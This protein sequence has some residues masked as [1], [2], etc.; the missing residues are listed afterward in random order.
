MVARNGPRR[1]SLIVFWAAMRVVVVAAALTPGTGLAKAQI[2]TR[3]GPGPTTQ[4][5]TLTYALIAVLLLL[6]AV[7]Q[8]CW[9]SRSAADGAGG[10]VGVE[11]LPR[12]HRWSRCKPNFLPRP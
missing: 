9:P 1:W 7:A 8:S 11:W 3:Y 12:R 4:D 2:N 5:N 10:I 6:V